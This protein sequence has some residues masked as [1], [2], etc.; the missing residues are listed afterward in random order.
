MNKYIIIAI[1][2]ISIIVF[3]VFAL[4][5]TKSFVKHEDERSAKW[6]EYNK[7]FK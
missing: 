1:A 2:L 6:D 5:A 4:T 7:R 3:G